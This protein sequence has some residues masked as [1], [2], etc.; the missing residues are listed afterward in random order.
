M[1]DLI[2]RLPVILVSTCLL[3]A[4][5]Q[6]ADF[7]DANGVGH[8]YSDFEGKWRMVNYWATWCGPCIK[9]I[10]ELNQLAETHADELVV[11][12]VNFDEPPG[13]EALKQINRMKIEFPVYANDPASQLGVEKPEVLPTTFVFRPDGSLH[14]TLVGPQTEESLLQAMQGP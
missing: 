2:F 13:D 1:R 12:G 14:A 4:C 9:E 11:L 8:R 5:G 3:L 6:P 10:P 7:Y